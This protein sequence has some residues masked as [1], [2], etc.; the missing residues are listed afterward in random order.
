VGSGTAVTTT[1]DNGDHPTSSSD[2]S[3]YAYDAAENMISK[4]V[5]GSSWSFGYD[6]W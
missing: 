5:P 4:S 2:G 3:T 1:Y 6:T